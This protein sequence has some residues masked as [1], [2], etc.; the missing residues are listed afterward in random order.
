MDNTK[1]K[2]NKTN[3][4]SRSGLRGYQLL[5]AVVLILPTACGWVDSTGSRDTDAVSFQAALPGQPE[6]INLVAEEPQRVDI[7]EIA[8]SSTSNSATSLRGQ[9]LQW[10]HTGTGDASQC[11]SL[12][13][14]ASAERSNEPGSCLTVSSAP[15][16]NLD[17]QENVSD[18][19]CT[20][21]IIEHDLSA[22]NMV[23]EIH[24]PA[25]AETITMIYAIDFI[26]DDGSHFE[27]EVNLCI[28]P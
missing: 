21:Y 13:S 26:A 19:H 14:S 12:L 28:H 16:T 23:Y 11:S 7:S 10:R 27:K 8:S 3:S 5:T 20:V 24:T 1:Y 9:P 2:S 17:L 22:G 18:E 4:V 15:Q 25:V 6:V